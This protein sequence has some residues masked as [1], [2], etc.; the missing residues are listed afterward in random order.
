MRWQITGAVP[1]GDASKFWRTSPVGRLNDASLGWGV[2]FSLLHQIQIFKKEA[3]RVSWH[4][5][6]L[7]YGKRKPWYLGGS[8][9]RH[10]ELERSGY[11]TAELNRNL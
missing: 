6:N 4:F 10:S 5:G 9:R 3:F 1:L 8:A 2:F 7:E 11:C